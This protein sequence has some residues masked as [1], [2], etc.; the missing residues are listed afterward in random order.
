MTVSCTYR[1][2]VVL[3]ELDAMRDFEVVYLLEEIQPVSHRRDI[4]ILERLV[5]QMHEHV[6]RNLV[7]CTRSISLD[8]GNL[9]T[10]RTRGDN[11]ANKQGSGER[12]LEELQILREL[13][14]LGE[15]VLDIVDGPLGD[16]ALGDVC[17]DRR[18]LLPVAHRKRHRRR[19]R[20]RAHRQRATGGNGLRAAGWAGDAAVTVA[21]C[22]RGESFGPGSGGRWTAG[23]RPRRSVESRQERGRKLVRARCGDEGSFTPTAHW[24]PHCS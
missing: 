23:A 3:L 17:R 8:S 18:R 14:A 15:P 10:S 20:L 22:G 2:I 9:I 19:G 6:S 13:H 21:G 5:V 11:S 7:I 1:D 4:Q 16:K 24:P 12:T